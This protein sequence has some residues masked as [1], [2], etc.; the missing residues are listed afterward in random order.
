MSIGLKGGKFVQLAFRV[1]GE[2][3]TISDTVRYTTSGSFAFFLCSIASLALITL[4]L[5]NFTFHN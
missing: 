5:V 2:E 3:D 1:S 4:D